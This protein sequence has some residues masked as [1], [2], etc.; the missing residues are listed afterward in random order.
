MIDMRRPPKPSEIRALR[1]RLGI[2]IKELA[3][4]QN[5]DPELI[6]GWEK[7]TWL[8]FHKQSTLYHKMLELTPH[9][10]ARRAKPDWT[11]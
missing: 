4:A 10:L 1:K 8:I 11:L 5:V 7:G 2:S 9:L 6:A 3:R